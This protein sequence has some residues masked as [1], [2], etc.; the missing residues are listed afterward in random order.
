M[1]IMFPYVLIN[2]SNLK[3]SIFVYIGCVIIVHIHASIA[4]SSGRNL[5]C[6]HYQRLYV[7]DGG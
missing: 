5:A 4:I 6:D 7:F 1:A 3:V 2:A